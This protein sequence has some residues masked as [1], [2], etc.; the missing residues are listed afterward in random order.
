[1]HRVKLFHSLSRIR[2]ASP[3]LFR[4]G[5]L[6]L[7]GEALPSFPPGVSLLL[8]YRQSLL[9]RCRCYFQSMH[10]ASACVFDPCF[11]GGFPAVEMAIWVCGGGGGAVFTRFFLFAG[12]GLV[13]LWWPS[14]VLKGG[15]WLS[16]IV[17]GIRISRFTALFWDF[18]FW[19]CTT[20]RVA[21]GLR[22]AS[23]R[24]PLLVAPS[25]FFSSCYSYLPLRLCLALSPVL[26]VGCRLY[27][28]GSRFCLTASRSRGWG[29]R[30]C[31]STDFT[32]GFDR[33]LGLTACEATAAVGG[34]GGTFLLAAGGAVLWRWAASRA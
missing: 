26:V 10:W 1:M 30:S 21:S 13:L 22:P 5:F 31:V 2:E 34:S 29:R 11:V 14:V 19:R 16:L 25:P 27:C 12:D 23:L 4:L 8:L 15:C 6:R 7:L 9:Y 17:F 33:V 18:G 20:A 24:L 32:V 28:W 3:L